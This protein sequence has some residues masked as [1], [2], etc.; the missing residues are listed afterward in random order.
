MDSPGPK[1]YIRRSMPPSATQFAPPSRASDDIHAGHAERA[2][3]HFSKTT[4]ADATHPVYSPG[5]VNLIGE[6]TD[7][8]GGFVLPLAIEPGIYIAARRRDDTNARLWSAQFPET[9]AEFN[10]GAV[11]YTH[12]TLPT[13]DLV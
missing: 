4:G 3:E 5:R 12:L 7:Y 9:P 8:N 13:S 1:S 10:V 2:L 6:H 11:S